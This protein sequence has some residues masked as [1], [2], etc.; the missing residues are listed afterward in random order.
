MAAGAGCWIV[1]AAGFLAGVAIPQLV[2]AMAGF[3]VLTIYGER[4]ELSRLI[5]VSR[6]SRTWLVVTASG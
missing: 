1:G 3:L 5:G 6:V 2:P 4:L